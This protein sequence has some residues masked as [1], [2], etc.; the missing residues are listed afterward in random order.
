MYHIS[1]GYALLSDSCN[2]VQ[3]YFKSTDVFNERWQYA[4]IIPAF[5]HALSFSLLCVIS[6]LWAPSQSSMR[7]YPDLTLTLAWI[8][9]FFV[10]TAIL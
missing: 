10:V 9:Y 2:F 4:W 5:W 6:Y 1:L 7:Y 3:I 8:N